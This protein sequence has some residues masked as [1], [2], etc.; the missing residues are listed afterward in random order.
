MNTGWVTAAGSWV[1]RYIRIAHHNV[2][3][4]YS[5]WVQVYIACVTT[6]I[7]ADNMAVSW[8]VAKCVGSGGMHRCICTCLRSYVHR[9][10]YTCAYINQYQLQMDTIPAVGSGSSLVP[11]I[12]RDDIYV[13]S[14]VAT[15]VVHI[16]VY[17]QIR[18]TRPQRYVGCG[19]QLG[20]PDIQGVV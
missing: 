16:Y 2:T 20:Y 19:V 6:G 5:I 7:T 1:A 4:V 8:I 12:C 17:R 13:P 11:M 3:R 18:Y 10:L 15:C 14:T 9:I